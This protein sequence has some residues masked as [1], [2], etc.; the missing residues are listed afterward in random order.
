MSILITKNGGEMSSV[1]FIR[2]LKTML[3]DGIVDGCS[4]T[5]S[6]TTVNIGAGHLIAGGAYIEIGN[7]S[8]NISYSGE[9]IVRVDTSSDT[10]AEM[11]IRPAQALTQQDLANGGTVYELQLATFT[12]SSGSLTALNVTV[13][14]STANSGSENI[15]V[16]SAQPS[17][18]NTG[19][20]WFW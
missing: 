17:S 19:D 5:K 2:L 7:A 8:I 14:K 3:T 6:G 4:I 10:P 20:L 11:M 13:G 15:Y 18:P 1:N 12:Y 16:Q 9:L